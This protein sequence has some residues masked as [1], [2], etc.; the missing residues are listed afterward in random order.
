[1]QKWKLAQKIASSKM[2]P[3]SFQ[4][5]S[6]DVFVAMEMAESLNTSVF[7]IMPNLHL[8]QGKP[9][10]SSVFIQSML[11]KSKLIKGRLHFEFTGT[12]NDLVCTAWAIDRETEERLEAKVSMAMAIAEGW[13]TKAGNKYKTMPEQMLSYRA[14]SMFVRRY[15]SDVM[16]GFST[17][18]EASSLPAPVTEEE[19]IDFSTHPPDN[20]IDFSDVTPTHI[21]DE[22]ESPVQPTIFKEIK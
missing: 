6:E 10:F 15:Y 2:I 12:V 16:L 13:A 20:D 4:N 9:S 11:N 8:I 14:T 17:V 18:E 22:Y 5:K 21:V 1:L 3:V 7:I 19:V